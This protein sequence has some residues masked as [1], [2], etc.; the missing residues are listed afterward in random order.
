MW[1]PLP[2]TLNKSKEKLLKNPLTGQKNVETSE[3]AIWEGSL[4]QDGQK[5]KHVKCKAEH[6]Q[7]KGLAALIRVNILKHNWRSM[8][9]WIIVNNGWVSEAKYYISGSPAA[10]IVYGQL[11]SR[12]WS[13]IKIRCH[14]SPQ[15]L[16]TAA[17]KI[18]HQLP[19][20]SWSTTIIR[21]QHDKGSAI[22]ITISPHDT[23]SRGLQRSGQGPPN[24][25]SDGAGTPPYYIYCI[26]LYFILNWA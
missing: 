17:I 10:I 18:H 23:E 21:C 13:T 15:S 1:H 9:W 12:S 7:D 2:L 4:S 24:W 22:I 6:H 19:P 5:W 25:W 14:Y 20:W 16:S 11:P 3:R 8:D 26:K